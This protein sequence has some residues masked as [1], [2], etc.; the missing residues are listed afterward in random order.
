MTGPG[1][2]ETAPLVSAI[3]P[4]VGRPSLVRAV[5]SALSQSWSNMEVIVSIDGTRNLLDGLALPHDPRLRIIAGDSRV[6]EQITRG[7]GIDESSGAFIALLDDDDVWLPTKIENQLTIAMRRREAGAEHVLVACRSDDVRPDGQVVR[8]VPRRLPSPGESIS[9]YLFERR[10][11]TPGET[12]IGNS[13]LLFDRELADMVPFD[14][15]LPNHTDWNWLLS[16]HLRT[17]TRLEFSPESLLRYTLNPP[18]ASVSSSSKPSWSS[19]WFLVQRPNLT[20]REFGDGILCCSVPLALQRRE[21]RAAGSL[22]GV[23]LK[24]GSPGLP[25]LTFVFLFGL[26]SVFRSCFRSRS[27][28]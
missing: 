27:T 3:I 12:A 7:R 1:P 5:E 9:K 23:S 20:A 10:Q 25:A 11:V 6:G 13:M 28:S 4:T 21:W 22:V 8:T 16:V 18:G 15:S 2:I 24:K 17:E 19:D 14:T 26:R